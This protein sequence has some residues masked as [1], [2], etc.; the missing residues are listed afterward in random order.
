MALTKQT[1][2]KYKTKE[3]ETKQTECKY[4]TKEE[5][6]EARKKMEKEAKKAVAKRK[7]SQE[8]D[9]EE[10]ELR[11]MGESGQTEDSLEETQEARQ[12]ESAEPPEQKKKEDKKTSVK[13]MTK[14]ERQKRLEELKAQRKEKALERKKA[15]EEKEKEKA[16]LKREEHKA[17]LKR[18][19]ALLARTDPASTAVR[20]EDTPT[21]EPSASRQET[22]SLETSLVEAGPLLVSLNPFEGEEEPV[23]CPTSVE[24]ATVLSETIHAESYIERPLESAGGKAQNS[25][26][27]GRY[28]ENKQHLRKEGRPQAWDP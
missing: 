15:K 11:D 27:E 24:P 21:T 8:E 19:K 26:L 2:Y 3:E 4:K 7:R 17:T 16:Q 20:E 25:S 6:E 22:D 13:I 5:E 14:E 18:A 12:T 23:I 9:L 10:G 28:P 1:E